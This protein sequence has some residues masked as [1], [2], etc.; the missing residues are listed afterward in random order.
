DETDISRSAYVLRIK[1]L[2]ILPAGT[3]F[4]L[5]IDSGA[6]KAF[7]EVDREIFKVLG[8]LLGEMI[9]RVMDNESDIGGISGSSQLVHKTRELVLKYSLEEDPVLLLGETGVGKNHIAR[10]IH[11]YSGRKGKFVI[12]N[13]PSIPVNLI[14]S[15]IFGHK[16]GAFTDAGSDKKGLVD[17]AEGGTLFLDEIAEIP[18]VFQAKLL[19]F[20]ETRKYQVLGNPTEKQ[21]DVRI[22]AATNQDLNK[23][24]EGKQFREDL[25][26]RL[27]VLEIDIP[28][29]RKRPG[30]I[31]DL[32]RA[33]EELLRG[34]QPGSG[35]FKAMESYNW[36]GNVRQLITLLR[37]LGIHAGATVTGE[38]V[39]ELIHQGAY[40]KEIGGDEQLFEQF[41][42]ELAGGESF[43]DIVWPLFIKR[44]LNKA[45]VKAFLQTGYRENNHSLKKLS[46]AINIEDAQFKR[47]IA[48]LHKYEIHP[49]K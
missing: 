30:D 28:P 2:M 42:G 3:G 27:Q 16:K 11:L 33:H 25:Y 35:F 32:V 6:R 29:L 40:K 4:F 46:Q 7:S 10:L 37:R 22:I 18:A 38:D 26:F 24:I 44:N 19:R 8:G 17:E 34:K 12:V 5:Y 15:E 47:F 1:S 39:S 23:L 41:R 45:Q 36:P 21:A 20:I 13:T 43:W 49:A 48:A 31:R 9:N 14:E